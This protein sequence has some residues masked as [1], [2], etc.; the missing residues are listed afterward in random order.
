MRRSASGGTRPDLDI[1]GRGSKRQFLTHPVIRPARCRPTA[2]RSFSSRL[3]AEVG[4]QKRSFVQRAANVCCRPVA[5]VIPPVQN[6]PSCCLGFGP[7]DRSLSVRF[8]RWTSR[9][10]RRGGT[11]GLSHFSSFAMRLQRL[12]VWQVLTCDIQ[13]GDGGKVSE[14]GRQLSTAGQKLVNG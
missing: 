8:W 2:P 12:S 4:V 11:T 5:E 13:A 6:R 7:A 1:R 3:Q 9:L 14:C 10:T